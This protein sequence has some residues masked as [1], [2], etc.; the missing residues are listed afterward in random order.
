MKNGQ[1][2][3]ILRD[4]DT[5]ISP[6]YGFFRA[7]DKRDQGNVDLREDSSLRETAW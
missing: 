3:I 5:L 2:Y 7:K 4:G 6:A 1:A